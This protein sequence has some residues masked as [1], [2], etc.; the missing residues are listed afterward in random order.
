M[1]V[2]LERANV[3]LVFLLE[4][5]MGLVVAP[6]ARQHKKEIKASILLKSKQ[7]WMAA[8]LLAHRIIGG[9]LSVPSFVQHR[10]TPAKVVVWLS[11]AAAIAAPSA[12]YL[13]ERGHH[14]DT[15]RAYRALS[16][17]SASELSFLRLSVGELLDQHSDLTNRLLAAGGTIETDDRVCVKVVATGYSSSVFETDNTPFITAANTRT[18]NGIIAL[19][20]DLLKEFTPGAP[21]SFGDRVHV[22]GFGDFIVEDVMNARWTQRVDVWFP[23]RSEAIRFGHRELVLSR[24]LDEDPRSNNNVL[25]ERAAA[26]TAVNEL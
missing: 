16:V 21:F 12:L 23:S 13:A 26:K 20:R 25:T 1:T 4:A 5:K 10:L 15:R 24:T 14:Q 7:A 6:Y 17:L 3:R 22:S 11:V 19:S 18:R 8:V 2:E 9:V